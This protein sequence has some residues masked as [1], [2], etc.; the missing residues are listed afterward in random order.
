[1]R[2]IGGPGQE[3][4]IR[5]ADDLIEGLTPGHVLADKAYDADHFHASILRTGADVVIPPKRN[6]RVQHAYD[7]VIY[8]ERN[9][10]ERLLASPAFG[11]TSSST[12]AA[13]QPDTTSCSPTSWAL[14]QS[15][16]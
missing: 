15:P 9:R 11:S 10:I 8:K 1:M 13:S 12:S 14:S 2:L 7:K 3:N 4:D 16:Q 5:R 6:R